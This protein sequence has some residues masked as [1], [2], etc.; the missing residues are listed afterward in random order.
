MVIFKRDNLRLGLILGLIGPLISVFGYY[1]IRFYPTFSFGDFMTALKTNKPLVTAVTIPC[2]LL[3]IILF[4]VYIN[5][6]RDQTA[7]GIFVI[8]LLYAIAALLFKFI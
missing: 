6:K 5:T 4:T 2:L 3:N 7:K 8:T 1:F